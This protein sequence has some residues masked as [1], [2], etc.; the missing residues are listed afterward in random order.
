MRQNK[1]IVPE[2]VAPETPEIPDVQETRE[3][4][5]VSLTMGMI[6][7][8]IG[9]SIHE[10]TVADAPPFILLSFK[11]LDGVPCD[12]LLTEDIVRQLADQCGQVLEKL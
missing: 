7:E 8:T 5:E 1:T 3:T 10:S 12:V 6:P 4:E 9:F 2:E 11:R